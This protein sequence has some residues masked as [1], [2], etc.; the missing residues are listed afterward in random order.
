MHPSHLSAD[1]F[2]GLVAEMAEEAKDSK[3]CGKV[4]TSFLQ[5]GIFRQGSGQVS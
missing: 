4:Q 5:C 2:S 1:F 3:P